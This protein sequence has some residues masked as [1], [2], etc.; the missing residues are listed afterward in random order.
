MINVIAIVL[1]TVLGLNA[2]S[3]MILALMGDEVREDHYAYII[4]AVS[5]VVILVGL[6]A[7]GAIELY[8]YTEGI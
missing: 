7:F 8:I 1:L 2:V 5:A 4:L 6:I 3:A